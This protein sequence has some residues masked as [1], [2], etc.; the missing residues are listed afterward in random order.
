MKAIKKEILNNRNKQHLIL[1]VLGSIMLLVVLFQSYETFWKGPV[2]VESG[3]EKSAIKVRPSKS[4]DPQQQ[5]ALQTNIAEGTPP[6]LEID[7]LSWKGNGDTEVIRNPFS[8]PP[9]PP[10]T[11]EPPPKPPTVPINA[12]SPSSVY[13]KTKPFE[14][15]VRG[16]N[17]NFTPEMRVYLNGSPS[18]GPTKFISANELRVL[19]PQQLFSSAQQM[20]VEVKVPSK[21]VEFFS[22][23]LS[24]TILEPPSPTPRF[25][26][27]GR[28]SESGDKN[29]LAVLLEGETRHVLGIDGK[30]GNTWKVIRIDR[31]FMV[32]EDYTTA[33][34]VQH[35][36]RMKEDSKT[37]QATAFVP[38]NTQAYQPA[39]QPSENATIE[40]AAPPPVQTQQASEVTE[41]SA[42]TA[43]IAEQP[44]DEPTTIEMF[45]QRRDEMMKRRQEFLNRMQQ[46]R[47]QG[48][49][50]GNGTGLEIVK[51]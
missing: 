15:L 18:F 40:Y 22:N 48:G 13:A 51:P 20:R 5:P 7:K 33:I 3:T 25:N 1:A 44:K 41:H 28:M 49:Q 45:K 36:L 29:P 12:V 2:A 10:P 8:Y 35:T 11:P 27:I 4:T 6:I 30:L 46:Q 24:L 32:V 47:Q 17:G 39:E 26:M 9:P 42:T 23:P 37:G 14:L 16:A 19:V 31:N 43:A 38:A 21:E 34:G 50:P